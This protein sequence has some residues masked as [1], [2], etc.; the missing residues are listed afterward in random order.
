[1]AD[2]LRVITNTGQNLRINV[3]TGATI[4][5][6]DINPTTSS[7]VI[8]AAA[9][10]NAFAGTATTRLFSIDQTTD[11]IYLQNA[12]AGTLGTSARLAEGLDFKVAAVL[13]SIQ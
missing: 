1:M 7:P 5:D 4:T 12:N 10:T 8:V 2:R 13:I 11:S 3:D 9:Y 6:L